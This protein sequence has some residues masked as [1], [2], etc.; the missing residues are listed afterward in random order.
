MKRQTPSFILFILLFI[1]KI[2]FSQTEAPF[3]GR[4]QFINGYEKQIS[5]EVLPYFS[6]YQKYAKEALLTRCTD[7]N[8]II[9]WETETIPAD[10]KTNY[11]YFTW[12]MGHS[13]GTSSGAR[14]FDL[15]INDVYTLTF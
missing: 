15:Y 5:G 10:S 4:Q 1:F 8:K 3:F 7:G 11:I 13:C 6:V 2:S 14:N 12:I 9:E